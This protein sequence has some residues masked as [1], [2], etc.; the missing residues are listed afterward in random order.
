MPNIIAIALFSMIMSIT[1]GP[2]NVVA[3]NSGVNVSDPGTT[4]Y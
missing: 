3:L 2:V 1:P 4:D